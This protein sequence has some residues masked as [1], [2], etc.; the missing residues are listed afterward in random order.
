MFEDCELVLALASG[1]VDLTR[2]MGDEIRI[3]GL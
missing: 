2:L 1:G 3:Y